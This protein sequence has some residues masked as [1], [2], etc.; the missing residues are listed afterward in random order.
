ME[1]MI[2][3]IFVKVRVDVNQLGEF[4]KKL[5]SGALK[6]HPLSTYCLANDPSV[7]LN[8][9]E[10]EDMEAFEKAFLPHREFYSEILEVEPVILPEV[11]MKKLF[12][13]ITG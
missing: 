10:A 7:G 11:A 12:S 6:T 9:W 2:M 4:G 5:Q 8:I 1:K 13:Q 3:Y